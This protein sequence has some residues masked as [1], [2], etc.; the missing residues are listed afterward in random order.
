MEFILIITFY[1]GPYSM[2]V[3]GKK[4][5]HSPPYAKKESKKSSFKSLIVIISGYEDGAA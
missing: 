4:K 1:T 5:L 2:A 3:H